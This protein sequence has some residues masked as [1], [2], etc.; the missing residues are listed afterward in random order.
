MRN[1]SEKYK[2]CFLKRFAHT[3]QSEDD[4]THSP[5]GSMT[6]RASF[7]V[8]L[9]AS[10]IRV[11]QWIKVFF[12]NWTTIIRR[13]R[14]LSPYAVEEKNQKWF[15]L[16]MSLTFIITCIRSLSAY[17]IVWISRWLLCHLRWDARSEGHFTIRHHWH[18]NYAHCVEATPGYLLPSTLIMEG[19]TDSR[20]CR[21]L[22]WSQCFTLLWLFFRDKNCCY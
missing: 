6:F 5:I 13:G 8:I 15:F 1:T 3:S 11:S 21:T 20:A 16:M 9:T 7:I 2:M 19:R 17:A 4:T 12:T 14:D 18:V 22:S 10:G